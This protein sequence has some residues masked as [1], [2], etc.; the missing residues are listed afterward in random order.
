MEGAA[1]GRVQRI[2]HFAF[3]KRRSLFHRAANLLSFLL[4]AAAN[5]VLVK[6]PDIVVVETDPFMLPTL[7]R[8]LKFWKGSK[9]VV[10]LQDVY[11]DADW[12]PCPRLV[13]ADEG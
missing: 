11:P 12:Q 6:R 9:L 13:S 10:Y 2:G 8:F 5:S 1:R 4:I 3:D 7:G